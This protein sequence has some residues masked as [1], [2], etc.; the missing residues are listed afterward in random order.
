[1]VDSK[2]DLTEKPNQSS[3][4]EI[5][6]KIFIGLVVWAVISWLLFMI[7]TAVWW[8]LTWIDSDSKNPIL[9]L[10]LIVSGFLASFIGNLWVAWLYSLFFSK[11]YY[12]MSKSIWILL[13]T[14]WM[15]FIFLLPI[16]I[17]FNWNLNWL[18]MILWFHIIIAT[19]LSS[20]QMENMR[21]P[22]YSASALIW[23]T[24]SLALVM[25]IYWFIR[26]YFVNVDAQNKT[27]IFLLI[28]PILSFCVI[29]LG[30]WIREIL[31]YK[32]FEIWNNPFYAES[33]WEL[34]KKE[35]DYLQKEE[36]LNE[37]DEDINIDLQ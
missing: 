37:I 22:N 14:N 11:K 23:N 5:F 7:L 18:F 15:L 36:K 21:N 35:L 9:P 32:F 19:F 20:Q 8:S 10:V 3:W 1:M 4:W 33:K 6:G 13:L 24:F 2:P 17:T 28:P 26:R 29:P 16:Y 27:Y 30:L 34:N 31:Y 12:N 25:L